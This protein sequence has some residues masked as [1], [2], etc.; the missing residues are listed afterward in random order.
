MPEW[1]QINFICNGRIIR[2]MSLVPV[3]TPA[4]SKCLE[5]RVSAFFLATVS[6]AFLHAYWKFFHCIIAVIT[7]SGFVISTSSTC[8]YTISFY[9]YLIGLIPPPHWRPSGGH[10]LQVALPYGYHSKVLGSCWVTRCP[11]HSED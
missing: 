8:T 2:W 5:N 11:R 3:P 6:L 4:P 9:D 10:D 7:K 1:K